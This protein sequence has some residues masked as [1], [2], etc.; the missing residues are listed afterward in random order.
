MCSE[1]DKPTP[2]PHECDGA[3]IGANDYQKFWQH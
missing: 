3:R 2:T 1:A